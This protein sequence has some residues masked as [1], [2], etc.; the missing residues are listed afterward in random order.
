MSRLMLH[1]LKIANKGLNVC[2]GDTLARPA[3]SYDPNG[4]RRTRQGAQIL[5]SLSFIATI[6]TMGFIEA[7]PRFQDTITPNTEVS[8]HFSEV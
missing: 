5:I 7:N 6:S 1:L 2:H 3:E 8:S 4:A